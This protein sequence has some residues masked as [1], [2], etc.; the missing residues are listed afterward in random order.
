MRTHRLWANERYWHT[1][2]GGPTGAPALKRIVIKNVVEFGTRFA[3]LQ[4]G[5]AD[6]IALSSPAEWPQ[7]DALAG[8]VCDPTGAC[9]PGATK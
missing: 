8:E 3:M 5:D 9:Q 6:S 7:L 4:A 1:E 2:P